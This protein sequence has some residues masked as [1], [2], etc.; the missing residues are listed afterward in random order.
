MTMSYKQPF[1][2]LCWIT[3]LIAMSFAIVARGADVPG[4]TLPAGITV[5]RSKAR[6]ASVELKHKFDYR[7]LLITGKLQTGETV[8]LTRMAQAAQQGAAVTISADGLVRAKQD[9]SDKVVYS[10]GDQSV[11]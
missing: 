5:V 10:Y 1:C 11:E 7:Q 8:D 9:G 2:I 3:A 4:E 6:P